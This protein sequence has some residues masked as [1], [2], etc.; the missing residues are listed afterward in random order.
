MRRPKQILMRVAILLAAAAAS[1]TGAY[2]ARAAKAQKVPG[3]QRRWTL[4]FRTGLEQPGQQ[5]PVE[6]A[7]SGDWTSTIVAVRSGEYDAALELVG[8]HLA[9]NAGGNVPP[10]ALEQTQRRLSRR[11]WAT[12][13]NDGT[14][15]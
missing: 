6:V 5:R 9:G 7:L 3:E 15:L 4:E 11:F 14:L 10:E 1:L 8:V 12:Y 2:L 13:G